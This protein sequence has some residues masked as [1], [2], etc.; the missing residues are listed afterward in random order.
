MSTKKKQ[1]DLNA[2][3]AAL[4][5]LIPRTDRLDRDRLMFLA[6]Q[7]STLPSPG[8][9]GHHA[10]HGWF[11]GRR[12][13]SVLPSLF[14]RGAGGEGS[15]R[16]WLWPTAFAAMSVVAATLLVMLVF[17]PGPGRIENAAGQTAPHS[18]LATDSLALVFSTDNRKFNEAVSPYSNSA[19]LHQI[20]TQ[21]IDSWKP[22]T[23][24]SNGT[25]SIIT[26][27]RTNWELM[28]QFIKEG[29]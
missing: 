1:D 28:N 26:R 2:F 5:G 9:D 29:A 3:E 7:Q 18:A 11:V 13:Q 12:Q 16:S 17:R 14:G 22:S 21:G 4:A 20:L 19:M 25:K 24:G 23:T 27:P 15:K 10:E 6:G 8:T